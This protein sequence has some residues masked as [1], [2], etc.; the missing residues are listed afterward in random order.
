[1]KHQ[2]P[3]LNL[4]QTPIHICIILTS[5]HSITQV[6]VG[7]FNDSNMMDIF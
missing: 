2:H 3:F 6:H 4:K 7:Q 1:M 5:N